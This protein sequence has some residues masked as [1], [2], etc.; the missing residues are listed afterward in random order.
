MFDYPV[1]LNLAG[2]DVLVV[3]GGRIGLRKVAGLAAAGARVRLVSPEVAAGFDRSQVVEHRRRP[4]RPTDLDGV[5]LVVTATGVPEVDEAVSSDAT[6][7]RLWVNAADRPEHCSF[8]LPA[9]ARARPLTV[10]VSSDGASPALA[11]W[12]RDRAAAVLTDDV[13]ALA[14][15]LAQ[16]R[17]QIHAAG[18]TTEAVD[19]AT[20]IE[21]RLGENRAGE[22]R[23]GREPTRRDPTGEDC[24]GEE[25]L[26]DSLVA[27]QPRPR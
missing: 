19:W 13:A 22:A 26:S 6:A 7:A 14:V 18:G 16:R 9:I 2:V 23:S 4:Y 5:A 11:G 15:E 25:R 8:I 12:V 17:A 1:Y 27:S 20:L 24:P 10:A 3:G 21:E